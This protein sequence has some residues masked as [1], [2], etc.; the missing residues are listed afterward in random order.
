MSLLLLLALTPSVPG[1]QYQAYGV[2][3]NLDPSDWNGTVHCRLE[4]TVLTGRS[5]TSLAANTYTAHLYNVT[6]AVIVGGS[7]V[8]TN[9]TTDRRLRSGLF[10]LA[11]SAKEYEVRHG[12]LAGGTYET[13]DADILIEVT[14]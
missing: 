8:S 5:F 7:S 6:D 9:S 10:S 14:P 13:D 2:R 3:R 12:G 11:V 1:A 4:V